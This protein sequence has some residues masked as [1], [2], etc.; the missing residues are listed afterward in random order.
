MLLLKSI[1]TK[2]VSYVKTNHNSID[3]TLVIGKK[4]QPW[5][6]KEKKNVEEKIYT[7]N[8]AFVENLHRKITV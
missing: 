1:L 2:V 3:Q 4:F 5:Q 8:I 7:S 6:Q